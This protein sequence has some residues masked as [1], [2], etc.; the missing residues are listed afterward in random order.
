V[1]Q[2]RSDASAIGADDRQAVAFR[3]DRKFV[4]RHRTAVFCDELCDSRLFVRGQFFDLFNDF[5]RTHGL[6]IRQYFFLASRIALL[7]GLILSRYLR[8][9]FGGLCREIVRHGVQSD[10]FLFLIESDEFVGQQFLP[11][12]CAGWK[13]V[14]AVVN[15]GLDLET[16]M[17]P[18]A[19]Q[20]RE[21]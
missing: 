19:L 1:N 5:K 12:G 10:V 13:T 11:A 4:A 2:L 9:A 6:I 16:V 21:P 17:H 7:V 8:V 20:G 18:A 14:A 3:A 15:N